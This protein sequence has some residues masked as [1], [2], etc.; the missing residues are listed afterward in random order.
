MCSPSAHF[1]SGVRIVWQQWKRR[2]FSVHS[3]GDAL[4]VLTCRFMIITFCGH[5]KFYVYQRTEEKL[6][7]LLDEPVGELFVGGYGALTTL[8]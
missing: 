5:S 3:F 7:F 6:L 8:Y 1:L 2:A 4:F